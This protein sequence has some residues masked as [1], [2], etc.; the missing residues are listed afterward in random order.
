MKQRL[1]MN[2]SIDFFFLDKIHKSLNNHLVRM[3]SHL[4]NH[5]LD[6]IGLVSSNFAFGLFRKVCRITI[7]SKTP[8]IGIHPNFPCWQINNYARSCTDQNWKSWRLIWMRLFQKRSFDSL[9]LWSPNVLT[10]SRALTVSSAS[11]ADSNLTNAWDL[12]LSIKIP[13]LILKFPFRFR[14]LINSSW[15]KS[16]VRFRISITLHW[17][18]FFSETGARFLMIFWWS[19]FSNHVKFHVVQNFHDFLEQLN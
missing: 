14:T 15:L 1:R 7:K 2:T 4:S 17:F 16:F 8:K 9:D 3:R 5:S 13:R 10:P 6:F 12:I 11:T 18:L 19:W